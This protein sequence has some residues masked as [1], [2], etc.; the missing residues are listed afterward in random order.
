[1]SEPLKCRVCNQVPKTFLPSV[2]KDSHVLK[3]SLSSVLKN[4]QVPKTFLPSVLKDSHVPKISLPL[5]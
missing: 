1:M 3:I 5:S 4:S 2:F